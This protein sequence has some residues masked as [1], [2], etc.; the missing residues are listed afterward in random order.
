MSCATV[1]FFQFVTGC[2][3][4]HISVC[5]M[6]LTLLVSVKMYFLL[7]SSWNIEAVIS[8]YETFSLEITFVE[9]LVRYSYL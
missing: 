9:Q 2:Y 1:Y 4:L 3:G 6:D 8:S 5:V 7:S